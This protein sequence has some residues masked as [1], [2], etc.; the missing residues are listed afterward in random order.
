MSLKFLPTVIENI[1]NSRID[2]LNISFKFNIVLKQLKKH[3]KES[4]VQYTF[5]INN[6]SELWIYNEY[7]VTVIED[8]LHR[9]SCIRMNN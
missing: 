1:I 9:C 7:D 6:L 2:E 5:G 8:N 3:V 4:N